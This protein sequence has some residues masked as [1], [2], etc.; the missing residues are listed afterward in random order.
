MVPPAVRAVPLDLSRGGSDG[1]KM[2]RGDGGGVGTM[3]A[4]P[5]MPPASTQHHGRPIPKIAGSEGEYNLAF[6]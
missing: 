4:W 1:A 6:D 5:T 2:K 3:T